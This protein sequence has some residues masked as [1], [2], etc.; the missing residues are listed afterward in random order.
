MDTMKDR[1]ILNNLFE[2]GERPWAV[3]EKG[4]ALA[5]GGQESIDETPLRA[6]PDGGLVGWNIVCGRA[7]RLSIRTQGAQVAAIALE[8]PDGSRTLAERPA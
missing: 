5:R 1:E 3:W 4:P 6:S 2:S 8:R 7:L